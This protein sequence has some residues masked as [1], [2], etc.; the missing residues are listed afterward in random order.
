VAIK[1]LEGGRF[2]EVRSS[3]GE[4][5][6]ESG[7]WVGLVENFGTRTKKSCET[8]PKKTKKKLLLE[9]VQR[10]RGKKKSARQ[11]NIGVVPRDTESKFVKTSLWAFGQTAGGKKKAGMPS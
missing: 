6:R 4:N 10:T 11:K 1:N 2:R 8:S 3:K 7:E 9:G 5:R